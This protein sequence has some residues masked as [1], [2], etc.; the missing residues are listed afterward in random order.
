MVSFCRGCPSP[1]D[2]GSAIFGIMPRYGFH[3]YH[4]TAE[5]VYCVP[6]HAEDEDLMNGHQFNDRVVF[7]DRGIVSL[8]DKVLKIQSSGASGIIIADDGQCTENFSYCGPRAGS[9]AEGGFAPDE[10]SS[11]Q[12]KSVSI[13]VILVTFSSAEKLRRLMQIE[14]VN[15]P[16]KG[17]QNVTILF[18]PD[19]S[20][21]EL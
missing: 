2:E 11:L 17:F 20:R 15:V 4:V 3:D 19:G 8:L 18:N 1:E 14:K 10:A 7:V 6:N 12:W 5:M 9:V 13:P 21:E 16:R